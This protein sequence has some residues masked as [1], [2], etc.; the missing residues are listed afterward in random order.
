MPILSL[1]VQ[2]PA[3][4]LLEVSARLHWPVHAMY[5]APLVTAA[6]AIF[7]LACL[8]A[9]CGGMPGCIVLHAAVTRWLLP[10]ASGTAA[11]RG[12]SVLGCHVGWGV[13]LP[14]AWVDGVVDTWLPPPPPLEAPPPASTSSG[15]GRWGAPAADQESHWGSG[16]AYSGGVGTRTSFAQGSRS[17]QPGARMRPY[18][19][20]E[21]NGGGDFRRSSAAPSRLSVQAGEQ[22]PPPAAPLSL[23]SH[24]R[25]QAPTAPH[26]VDDG[27]SALPDEKEG[28][29]IAVPASEATPAVVAVVQAATLVSDADGTSLRREASAADVTDAEIPERLRD[30]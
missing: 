11:A 4:G 19:P 6:A 15:I 9:V 26:D 29:A 22:P 1:I 27:A 17:G 2:A 16:T 7:A 14:P 12:W 23:R 8:C 25:Q 30:N 20:G 3:P 28:R 24:R 18:S 13:P 21:W 5:H 10:P